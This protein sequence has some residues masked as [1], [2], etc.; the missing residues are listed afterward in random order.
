MPVSRYVIETSADGSCGL[1]VMCL[2]LRLQRER[3]VAQSLRYELAAFVLRQIGNLAVV[4]FMHA[5][6]EVDRHMGPFEL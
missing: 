4:S 3:Q 5:L 2:M 1:G 6:G